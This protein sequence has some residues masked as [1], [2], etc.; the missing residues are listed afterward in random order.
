MRNE[1]IKDHFN[2]L[3]QTVSHIVS[4]PLQPLS[5]FRSIKMKIGILVLGAVFTTVFVYW[6]GLYFGNAW[7]SAAGIVAGIVALIL[8]RFFA[9]GLTTPLR[10][11]A[12]LSS[13]IATGNYDVEIKTTSRDEI[14]A[15]AETFNLMAKELQQTENLRRELIANASHELKT[16]LTALQA[17]LENLVDGVET[18]DTKK[19]Q[20][21]L[22]QTEHLSALVKDLLDLSKLESGVTPLQLAQVNLNSLIENV[23]LLALGTSENVTIELDTKQIDIEGDYHRL[24]Q[25]FTNLFTN[26]IKYAGQDV[27]IVCSFEELKDSIVINVDDN[28]PGITSDKK[29][30]VFER[31]FRVDESRNLKEGGSGIGLAITKQIIT[32]HH[33]TITISDSQMGGLRIRIELPQKQILNSALRHDLIKASKTKT[34][35]LNNKISTKENTKWNSIQSTT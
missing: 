15:L 7:P 19:M 14:G 24:L 9:K 23:K 35:D 20:I 29:D 26:S 27:K 17:Q 12:N 1:P 33:G 4:N 30:L 5:A 3:S 25:V 22:G 32:L 34:F 31:F 8:T 6:L 18:P 28:G 16:P 13:K 10:E 11:M 2:E 21:L